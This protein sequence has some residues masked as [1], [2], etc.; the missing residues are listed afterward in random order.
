M[1]AWRVRV[2]ISDE[3]GRVRLVHSLHAAKS[4]MALSTEPGAP[5][6]ARL[7][8]RLQLAESVPCDRAPA[9]ATA[10][11]ASARHGAEAATT[12]IGA[13]SLAPARGRIVL[14]L[15][16][17]ERVVETLRVLSFALP[18]PVQ[19]G[20]R[21]SAAASV[22]YCSMPQRAWVL[23]HMDS[24]GVVHE[25]DDWI[26]FARLAFVCASACACTG[27]GVGNG[28]GGGIACATVPVEMAERAYVLE[29]I[30]LRVREDYLNYRLESAT[31]L[32]DA[33]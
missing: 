8:A 16:N 7:H 17:S 19:L 25:L 32:S 21:D 18:T 11:S 33:S 9:P 13:E 27:G 6:F 31:A 10:P 2:E 26:V 29:S 3:S 20:A 5:A 22:S 24:Y 4:S 15:V 30:E 28:G 14:F 23:L 12:Y 1:T